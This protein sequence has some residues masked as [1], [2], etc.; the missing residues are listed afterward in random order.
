[1]KIDKSGFFS[2][3]ILV[4][5]LLAATLSFGINPGKKEV[6]EIVK[7]MTL[8][9]KAQLIVGTGM[10]FPIPDSIREKMPPGFGGGQREDTPYNRMVDKVRSYLPGTAGV[11]AE[12]PE[13]GVTSQVLSDG[14]AGL[15]IS[16]TRKDDQSTYYCTAF[17]IATVMASTWDTELVENVGKAMGKEV[18]EYGADVI[19]GPALNLQRDPLCGRNFEYYSEVPVAYE[20]GYGKS[21]T[22][23]EYSNLK[24]SSE[25]FKDKIKVTVE[26]RNTGNVTGREVVQVY[27]GAPAGKIEKPEEE[28][29]AFGK[30]G[31]LK[32][33]RSEKLS[34]VIDATLLASFD[35]E[36]SSWLAEAGDYILKVG[37]SS[38]DIRLKDTFELT[39]DVK[40]GTVSKAL[41]P[42]IEIN[43]LHQWKRFFC[44]L[45]VLV[46]EEF[47]FYYL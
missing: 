36:S 4:N 47:L 40:V 23:F 9:Q 32:P 5:L 28:L 12:F 27:A 2:W 8:E 17:P 18:L 39:G 7:S 25:K 21:Y 31:L 11:T 44:F 19:L 20:F 29:V 13:L 30:T 46:R 35:E 22:T 15:R 14:P 16:P 24:L 10:Y 3:M 37:A 45:P 26:V 33:G 6:K 43:R 34:F 42:Q 38:K 41:V 1:M